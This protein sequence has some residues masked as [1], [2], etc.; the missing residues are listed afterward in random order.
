MAQAGIEWVIR[1]SAEIGRNLNRAGAGGEA[2]VGE[3]ATFHASLG[4]T[5]MKTDAPWRDQTGNARGSLF[6]RAEG[7]DVV[8]GGTA[9]Y[10]AYLELGTTRMA[11]YPV[12]RPTIDAIASDYVEDAGEILMRLLGGKT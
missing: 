2:A 12:I 5:R 8:L 1:P 10:I 4:E 6:G 11:A 9:N 3:M 7:T